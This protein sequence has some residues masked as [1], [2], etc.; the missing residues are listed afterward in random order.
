MLALSTL[1]N[2]WLLSLAVSTNKLKGGTDCGWLASLVNAL[3]PM[4]DKKTTWDCG[5]VLAS[6]GPGQ[7]HSLFNTFF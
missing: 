2:L 5:E 1:C 7:C 4:G 3:R 6:F